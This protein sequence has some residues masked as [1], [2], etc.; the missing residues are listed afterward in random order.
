MKTIVLGISSSISIY[1][2]C[3]IVRRFQDKGETVQVIMTPNAARLIHPRLFKALTGRPVL[4]DL[5]EEGISEN[6]R[7]VELADKTSLFLVAPA[8]ANVIGKMASGVADDFLTTFYLAAKAPAAVAPAMNEKMYLHFSVQRNIRKLKSRGVCFIEPE[9]GYLACGTS[10]W[11]RLASP[12]KIVETGLSLIARSRNLQGKKVLV[13][14]GPTREYMDP[15]RYI[16]NRSS[17]K[18]GWEMAEEAFR[19]GAGVTLISGP[20]AVQPSPEIEYVQ[21]ET[22]E[23][24][25]EEIEIRLNTIDILV[26]AAAVSDYKFAAV[27]PE[28]RKKAAAGAIPGLVPSDDILE[29]LGQRK[30]NIFLVGFAAE[31]EDLEKNA[32]AKLRNKN[33][34]MIVAN[35]ISRRDAGFDSDWNQVVIFRRDGRSA[36]TPRQSKLEISRRI[37]DEIEDLYG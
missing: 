12:E 21:V 9:L 11:G 23:E 34:D 6:I 18:M 29:K 5:F 31:T 35:D 32:L 2:S 30:E 3:E 22:G 24:M 1:K 13:T 7:H 14:A 28:K 33:A 20:A 4:V 36:E 25:A 37:W 16:S 17:G 15:V 19:R 8:T 26:M 27:E 10:G